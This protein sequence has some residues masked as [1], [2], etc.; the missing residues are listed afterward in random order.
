MNAL[1]ATLYSAVAPAAARALNRVEHTASPVLKK[2]RNV[3]DCIAV[4]NEV[5]TTSSV[6]V[7]VEP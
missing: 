6:A 7:V 3:A 4:G 2:V 1:E 5:P